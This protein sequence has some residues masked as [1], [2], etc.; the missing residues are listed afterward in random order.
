MLGQI[1]RSLKWADGQVMRAEMDS[2]VGTG[3]G[4]TPVSA[5]SRFSVFQAGFTLCKD[6]GYPGCDC[7]TLK[8]EYG[9]TQLKHSLEHQ[10]RLTLAGTDQCQLLCFKC[11]QTHNADPP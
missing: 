9:L 5:C 7:R 4:F 8:P 6:S 1:G 11:M 3:Y 2:Q 10:D